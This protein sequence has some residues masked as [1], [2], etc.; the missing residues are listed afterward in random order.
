MNTQPRGYIIYR[1]ASMIDGKPIVAIALT[2]SKNRKTGN[3]VQ[4]YILCDNGKH[5]YENVKA[6]EDYSI[7]GNCP[8][9]HGKGGGCYVSPMRG[10]G[11]VY[12]AFAK[13]LYPHSLA[14]AMSAAKGR[15]VRL[16]TYGDPAAVPAHIWQSL[17]SFAYG[18]TG[19]THQWKDLS[20][21]II[22]PIMKMCM[23]S[24]DNEWEQRLAKGTGYR[25]FRVR[26]PEEPIMHSEFTCPAAE[27]AGRK[28]ECVSCKACTGGIASTKA[29]VTIIA[30]GIL[31][32][33]LAQPKLI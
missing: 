21:E 28:R 8:H 1:G 12:K 16:G 6:L 10:P 15:M 7:C 17:L 33:R 25:T 9:R 26:T 30:H 19:Y 5:P 23:A 27:E 11:A 14:G 24:V 18:H 31:A 32:H 20:P 29:D 4:T 22:N 13:G 2:H 3:M